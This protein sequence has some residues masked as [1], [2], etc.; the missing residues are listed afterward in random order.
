[1]F[2]FIL[3][4]RGVVIACSAAKSVLIS[5]LDDERGFFEFTSKKAQHVLILLRHQIVCSD[6]KLL[7]AGGAWMPDDDATMMHSRNMQKLTI[8]SICAGCAGLEME[9]EDTDFELHYEALGT[10][11]MRRFHARFRDHSSG[12]GVTTTRF[13]MMIL[14]TQGCMRDTSDVGRLS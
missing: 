9:V 6:L 12:I 8:R 5:R 4:G 10:T 11:G 1:M 7:A 3:A 14:L 13:G 2:T